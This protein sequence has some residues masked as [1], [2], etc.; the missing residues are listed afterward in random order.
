MRLA[1]KSDTAAAVVLIPS[2]ATLVL[3]ASVVM[4]RADHKR[5]HLIFFI[6]PFVHSPEAREQQ[7]LPLRRN[8]VPSRL[9]PNVVVQ[10]VCIGMH[11]T[12][13][14]SKKVTAN[15]A[16]SPGSAGNS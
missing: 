6:L 10:I 16:I 2:T 15:K 9:L 1:S 8:R 7:I 12:F 5:R 13:S 3:A 11:E 4:V 14:Y